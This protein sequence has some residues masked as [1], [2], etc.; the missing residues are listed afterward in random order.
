[1]SIGT[2]L[3]GVGA[4]WAK[5]V[6]KRFAGGKLRMAGAGGRSGC[7]GLGGRE[8]SRAEGGVSR[9]ILVEANSG[10]VPGLWVEV[11]WPS[12][13]HSG[14]CVCDRGIK[15]LSELD[16]DGLRIRISGVGYQISEI[17]KVV[18]YCSTTLEV[19]G[20]LQCVRCHC[21]RV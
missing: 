8:V 7:F 19:G 10:F 18:I 15:S 16:H 6:G 2:G 11:V 3:P 1:M 20:S 14:Y 5:R 4:V 17:I 13:S 9:L 12:G 21:I